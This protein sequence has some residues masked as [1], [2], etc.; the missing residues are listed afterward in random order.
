MPWVMPKLMMGP[1]PWQLLPYAIVKNGVNSIADVTNGIH[2]GIGNSIV[3]NNSIPSYIV[4]ANAYSGLHNLIQCLLTSFLCKCAFHPAWYFGQAQHFKK[5]LSSH[6][7]F[8]CLY[9]MPSLQ[10]TI[11][12][13]NFKLCH[14]H[15]HWQD[16]YYIVIGSFNCIAIG[17]VSIKCL[18]I[19]NVIEKKTVALAYM[20]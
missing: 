5:H 6:S 11:E 15:C 4:M 20:G 8:T 14:C 13:P 17:I 16:M 10:F 18:F 19:A 9:Y 12:G 1:M 7:G 3:R 2:I